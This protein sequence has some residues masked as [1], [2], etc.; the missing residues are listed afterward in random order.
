[1]D[2]WSIDHLPLSKAQKGK[3]RAAH[4]WTIG[5]VNAAIE[6]GTLEGRSPGMGPEFVRS[7]TNAIHT[8]RSRNRLWWELGH[9]LFQPAAIILGSVVGVLGLIFV[10]WYFGPSAQQQ[11]PKQD[12]IAASAVQPTFEPPT[13]DLPLTKDEFLSKLESELGPDVGRASRFRKAYTEHTIRKPWKCLFLQ[14]LPES[15]LNRGITALFESD[16][17]PKR[18]I[19]ATCYLMPGSAS[20]DDLDPRTPLML[21]KGTIE[22]IAKD[23]I[24]LRDCVFERQ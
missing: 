24:R 3:L 17:T 21:L 10:A 8:A 22:S 4:L 13:P 12:Q 19:E 16:G 23:H 6:S 15:Q 20:L 18:S 11:V 14:A 5:D 9:L 7:V 2:E 1:M